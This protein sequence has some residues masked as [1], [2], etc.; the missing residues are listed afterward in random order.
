MSSLVWPPSPSMAHYPL[1][2]P[3]IDSSD[4]EFMQFDWTDIWRDDFE[5]NTRLLIVPNSEHSLATGLEQLLP[6]QWL[7]NVPGQW[8]VNVH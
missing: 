6:C 8:L 7:V 1:V 2:S 3:K 4:D 5:K